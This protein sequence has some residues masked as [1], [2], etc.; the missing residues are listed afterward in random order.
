MRAGEREIESS[1]AVVALERD[2]AV[3][4]I[5]AQLAGPGREDCLD[6][7]AAIDARRR[8]AMPS[9][10]RCQSCEGRRERAARRGS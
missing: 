10:L 2:M 7:G 1:E 3:G 5:R 4:R 9:A 8:A 6:C